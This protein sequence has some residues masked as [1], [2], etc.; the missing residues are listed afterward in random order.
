[1]RVAICGPIEATARGVMVRTYRQILSVLSGRD[2]RRF[3]FVIALMLAAGVADVVGVAAI[4]PL[5]AVLADPG[6]IEGSP[7]LARAYALGGFTSVRGFLGT[8]CVAAFAVLTVAVAVR[9]AAKYA[10]ARFTRGVVLTL[11]QSLL[12]KYLRN[13]Y[14]WHLGRH[15][16][17]LAKSLLA[18]IQ[19]VV[20]GSVKPAM[21]FV[22]D[23][24][25]AAAMVAFLFYLEPG[26]AL[27][28]G[29]LVAGSFALVQSRLRRLLERLGEDRRRAT[30]ERFK[31]IQESLTGIKDVKILDLEDTYI[32][33]FHHP[34]RRIAQH[35]ATLELV[36]ELPRY[37]LE[38]LAFGGMLIFLFVL[39]LMSQGD[40]GTVLP[41]F[42]AFTLAGL[43]LLPAVQ[44]LFQS[45]A[46]MRF[47]LPALDGLLAEL[48]EATGPGLEG[49][50]GHALPLHRELALENVRYAYPGAAAPILDGVSLR[51][52]ART[53]C[54]F[55][56]PTGAGKTTILDV[57]LGLLS[58]SDGRLT[59]DGI[60]IDRTN[61]RAWQGSIGYVQQSIHLID[62]TIAANIAYGVPTEKIDRE[63]AR[64]AARQASL[65]D[66]VETL[67]AGYDTVVGERGARLSGGQRQRLGIAR[68]L[69]RDPEVIVFDEATSALDTVTERAVMEALGA[70]GGT[71][72][73]IV[74]T[75]RLSTVAA[76]D[77]IAVIVDGRVDAEGTYAD[78]A[79][80]NATFRTLLGDAA[81]SPVAD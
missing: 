68:A 61:L 73:V 64:R 24:V 59:V 71:R 2:R 54:G 67:P 1:M 38:L 43:R 19:E 78:L 27:L 25:A 79:R 10:A 42:G 34:S 37:L 23:G 80:S 49:A 77:K 65:H 21:R 48:R 15:S 46:R 12:T 16:S 41:V 4:I 70:L 40:L 26:G 52:P 69:Y 22:S 55:V 74:V 51:I 32:D 31:I 66:F 5:L 35:Q 47:G 39:I 63:A 75:H 8:L 50:R 3:A 72:T 81:P 76:C 45:S 6:V 11:S 30:R 7:L 13:P 58:P 33:R 18:E 56:G 53:S 57:I 20:Q 28:V 14:E 44:V 9:V 29:G 60:P 62:D 36:A 17:D